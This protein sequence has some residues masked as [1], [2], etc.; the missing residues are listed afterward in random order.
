MPKTISISWLLFLALVGILAVAA[1]GGGDEPEDVTFDLR[2]ADRGIVGA[3]PKMEVTQDDEVTFNLTSDEAAS[4]HLHG[5]D[6]E[7]ELHPQ[8]PSSVTFT[9]DVA[10]S[11]PI[12]IHVGAESGG[13]D[14]HAK[15]IEAPQEMSV[16]VSA[17]PDD[18]SGANLSIATTGLTFAPDKVDQ[19]HVPGEGH[20]HVYVD[21]VKLGRVFAN[22]HYI[23]DLK[24]GERT[25][26]ITLNANSHEQ[27]ARG[28]QPVEATTTVV[29]PGEAEEMP[30]HQ[31]SASEPTEIDLGRLTVLP[32]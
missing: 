17:A 26:R 11:F 18:K 24:P 8:M 6:H 31:T 4:F 1:C 16:S 23:S 29:I 7:L 5:Y 20:A 21:G 13:E 9:A 28:G 19:P 30:D 25:I 22:D 10:G 27:F 14:Q 12:T 32:R 3:E 15:T 2:I